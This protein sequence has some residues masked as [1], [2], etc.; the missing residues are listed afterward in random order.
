M[1][2]SPSTGEDLYSGFRSAMRRLAATVNVVTCADEDGWHGMTA[3]AVTSVC[4]ETPALLVCV[5]TSAHFYRRLL[6]ASH[7]CINVL[8]NSHMQIS[9]VFGDRLRSVERFETGNWA[10]QLCAPYLIDAQANFFC[11]T[12]STSN[13]GT[14]DI[15]VGR[16]EDLR[17]TVCDS[18]LIYYDGGYARTSQPL[19]A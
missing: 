13:F 1:R 17:F 3:T 10:L 7:F 15:F 12:A 4:A 6:A 8:G 14:H 18:P 9:E 5:D 11:R 19:E 16:V 2:K